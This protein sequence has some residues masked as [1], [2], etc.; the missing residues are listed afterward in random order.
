MIG[1]VVRYFG[2]QVMDNG[3]ALK[4]EYGLLTKK[5]YTIQKK[6]ISGF[7]YHQSFL[8]KRLK[9]GTL[10]LYAIGTAEDLMRRAARI[11][12]CFR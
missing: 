1:T 2:F 4:I 3:E 12:F 9:T 6:K 8:M 7:S 5:R 11:R 10:Q